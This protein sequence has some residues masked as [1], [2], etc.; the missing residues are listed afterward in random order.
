MRGKIIN[1]LT[2]K[3]LA[4]PDFEAPMM[5][6]IKVAWIMAE[7]KYRDMSSDELIEV[8]QKIKKENQ[9]EDL[10]QGNWD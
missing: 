2:L 10:E 4:D 6:R 3:Y 5:Q 8:W 9:E 7:K 1:Y